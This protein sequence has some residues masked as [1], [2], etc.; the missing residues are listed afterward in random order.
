MNPSVGGC[1]G[2]KWQAGGLEDEQ[3]G[4]SNGGR[5]LAVNSSGIKKTGLRVS[6]LC[7]QQKQTKYKKIQPNDK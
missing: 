5:L 6:Q 4:G 2:W 1:R 3:R 7:T